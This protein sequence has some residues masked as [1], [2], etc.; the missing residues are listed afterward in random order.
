MI[1]EPGQGTLADLADHIEKT[2]RRPCPQAVACARS[3][4]WTTVGQA[5]IE[6]AYQLLLEYLDVLG[7][8]F[9]GGTI[10]RVGSDPF[11]AARSWMT[12]GGLTEEEYAYLFV[13]WFYRYR[14]TWGKR[15][16]EGVIWPG[17]RAMVMP[18]SGRGR[19]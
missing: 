9:R 16:E 13:R 7:P 1:F 5:P 3:H 18:A 17:C 15:A 8:A 6:F 4:D 12:V 14:D 11:W 2:R 19:S 10:E